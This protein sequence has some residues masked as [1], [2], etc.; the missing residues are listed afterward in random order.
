MVTYQWILRSAPEYIEMTDNHLSQPGE[1]IS[2]RAFTLLC[3][4]A[5]M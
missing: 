5:L 1:E 2:A 3:E 4:S